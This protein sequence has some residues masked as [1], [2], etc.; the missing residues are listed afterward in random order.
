MVYVLTRPCDIRTLE[1]CLLG[2]NTLFYE[3]KCKA[4]FR[5]KW[6]NIDGSISSHIYS[7]DGMAENFL[8]EQI[9]NLVADDKHLAC[10]I[11]V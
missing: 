2:V 10:A 7:V 5:K 8:E 11:S 9:N 3:I 4:H 1:T 6:I